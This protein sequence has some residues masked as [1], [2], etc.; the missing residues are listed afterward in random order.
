MISYYPH[1]TLRICAFTHMQILCR[2]L[3]LREELRFENIWRC[4]MQEYFAPLG[5][6]AEHF[7]AEL[8]YGKLLKFLSGVVTSL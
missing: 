3:P 6:C 1:F 7:L 2:S 4:P 8:I 5:L